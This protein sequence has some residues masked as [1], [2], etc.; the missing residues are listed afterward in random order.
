MRTLAEGFDFLGYHFRVV[1]TRRN[2]RR[3]FAACWPSRSAVAAARD[4]IRALTPLERVGLPAILVVQDLNRFLR[5]WGAYFRH[6]NST[7][8]FITSTSSSS[9]GW[10]AS[11][12]AST[13]R[14]TGV[15]ARLT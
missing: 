1:P 13:A 12:H 3:K 10:R 14:G 5:G 6:G 11:S 15:A 9:S 2:P 7:R 4:R 8:Q